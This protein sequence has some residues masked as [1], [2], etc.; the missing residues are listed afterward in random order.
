M[1]YM[2]W[3]TKGGHLLHK[4]CSQSWNH[5]IIELFELEGNIR[6]HLVQPPFT[7]QDT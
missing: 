6:G 3:V 7:E 1:R 2:V 4:G 5:K